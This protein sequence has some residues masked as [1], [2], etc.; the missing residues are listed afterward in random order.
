MRSL[1]YSHREL[2]P[3]KDV[4]FHF[5]DFTLLITHLPL[6]WEEPVHTQL[7]KNHLHR[8][9]KGLRTHRG[10]YNEGNTTIKNTF[11]IVCLKNDVKKKTRWQVSFLKIDTEISFSTSFYCKRVVE[12]DYKPFHFLPVFWISCGS[13]H[14]GVTLLARLRFSCGI[15]RNNLNLHILPVFWISYG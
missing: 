10:Q 14:F 7:D 6:N 12:L 3:F 13:V 9:W 1:K 8:V 2:I 4:I 15:T 5:W 11:N